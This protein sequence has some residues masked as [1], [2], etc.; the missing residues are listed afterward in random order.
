MRVLTGCLAVGTAEE[1]EAGLPL[2]A[3]AHRHPAAPWGLVEEGDVLPGYQ[4]TNSPVALLH[5]GAPTKPPVP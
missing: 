2:V 5:T 1:E 4:V 3:T